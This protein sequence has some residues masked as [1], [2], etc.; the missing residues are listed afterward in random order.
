MLLPFF[1]RGNEYKW[2]YKLVDFN[3]GFLCVKG[4]DLGATKKCKDVRSFSPKQNLLSVP[5]F[6]HL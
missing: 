2:S 4:L 1:F 6:F 3:D 5:L